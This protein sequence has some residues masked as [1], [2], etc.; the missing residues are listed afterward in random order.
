MSHRIIGTKTLP[1]TLLCLLLILSL[2]AST[3]FVACTNNVADD[4][5]PSYRETKLSLPEDLTSMYSLEKTERGNLWLLGAVKGGSSLSLW[6]LDKDDNWAHL[7]NLDELLPM[8]NGEYIAFAAI[9]KN[10]NI[11]CALSEASN[12]NIESNYFL[13]DLDSDEGIRSL[14]IE[15]SK[16]F[17]G[18]SP[19][20]N[21]VFLLEGSDGNQYLFDASDDTFNIVSFEQSGVEFHPLSATENDEGIFVLLETNGAEEHST[22][23]C[24]LDTQTNTLS[25]VEESAMAMLDPLLND[26]TYAHFNAFTSIDSDSYRPTRITICSSSGIYEFDYASNELTKVLGPELTV[27]SNPSLY[28]AGC[29]FDSPEDFF[30]ISFN[31]NSVDVGYTVHKYERTGV[32][33]EPDTVLR[34]YSLYDTADIRQA[35]A[36]FKDSNP[37]VGVQ[38]EIGLANADILPADAIK[39]LNMEIL[40]GEGPDVINLDGLPLESFIEQGALLDISDIYQETAS[41]GLY[42]ED[43]IGSYLV[44]GTCFALPTRFTFPLIVAHSNTLDEIKSVDSLVD[45]VEREAGNTPGASLFCGLSILDSLFIAMYSELIIDSG[46]DVTKLE[47]FFD[48]AKKISSMLEKQGGQSSVS[49]HSSNNHSSDY[50]SLSN[51]LYDGLASLYFNTD[52]ILIAQPKSEISFRQLQSVKE[53][54][55]S[56]ISYKV[57][58]L[59]GNYCYVSKTTMAISSTSKSIDLSK[60]FINTMLSKDFQSAS[61]NDGLAVYIPVFEGQAT[62]SMFMLGLDEA[63]TDNYIGLT[64]EAFTSEMV[65]DYMALFSTLN[66]LVSIDESI[67]S[68]AYDQLQRYLDDDISLEEAVLAAQTTIS[69]YLKE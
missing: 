55:S 57:L 54:A 32:S 60:S 5:A 42:Y 45:F 61:Q 40:A 20:R 31:P 14:N 17:Y 22:L 25:V 47:H 37:G 48:A 53:N 4:G 50:G 39:K 59:S 7:V 35:V 16:P 13:V 44:D 36:M 15:F 28:T 38:L 34:V 64:S 27:L 1:K 2:L 6:E 51:D 67:K 68:I 23:L 46:V 30:L 10:E 43:I 63:G 3:F 11:F 58:G 69:I 49:P 62:G 18:A 8:E 26:D 9:A 24:T 56:D 41:S 12:A 29:I 66:E 65:Q 33:A 21:D 52:Q 19:L